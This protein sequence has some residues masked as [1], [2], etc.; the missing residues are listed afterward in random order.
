MALLPDYQLH[1]QIEG[2]KM[3][4]VEKIDSLSK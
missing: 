3:A 4:S 2:Q 1:L